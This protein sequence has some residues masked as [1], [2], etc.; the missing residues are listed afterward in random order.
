MKKVQKSLFILLFVLMYISSYSQSNQKEFLVKNWVSTMKTF[1]TGDTIQHVNEE[2]NLK[3][4]GSMTWLNQGMTLPGKWK[5]LQ[6]NNQL[7]MTIE[8]G[9]K[10]ETI[11]LSI[12]KNTDKELILT[13]KK[14]KRSM[15]VMYVQNV[16]N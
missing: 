12:D 2:L 8:M 15:T 10:S 6:D 5:Y 4:N 11:A 3:K 16:K 7:Q 1:E 9:G 13:Q 14:G